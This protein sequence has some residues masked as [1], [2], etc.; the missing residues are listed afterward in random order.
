MKAAC[1]QTSTLIWP[2]LV[3]LHSSLPHFPI[4]VHLQPLVESLSTDADM[5]ES[6]VSALTEGNLGCWGDQNPGWMLGGSRDRPG[7]PGEATGQT[8]RLKPDSEGVV[9]AVCIH[10]LPTDW[11]SPGETVGGTGY[12][13][14][15]V[16]IFTGCYLNI[17]LYQLIRKGN[18]SNK[19]P[20]A[21]CTGLTLNFTNPS[22]QQLMKFPAH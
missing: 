9:P 6:W 22:F 14:F 3:S 10:D 16:F 4:K 18:K 17:K 20:N 21:L 19:G 13:S 1:R 11:L 15:L 5:E 8:G 7:T 12:S 2:H